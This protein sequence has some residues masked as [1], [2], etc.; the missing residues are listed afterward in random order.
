MK[1]Q[2]S[3]WQTRLNLLGALI[4]LAGL[5]SAAVIYH[6]SAQAPGYA[7]EGAIL[8]PTMS[9]N[10]KRY[11]H[12]LEVYGGRANVMLD[13]FSRWFTGLW[14]GKAL[15]KTIAFLSLVIAAGFFYAANHQVPAGE[16]A[17]PGENQRA[18][19]DL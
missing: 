15:A 5:L 19:P 11:R 8:Y 6:H 9:E 4:L 16:S 17:G 1:W 3:D 7:G 14:Q 13:D 10:T 12:E 18:G 2:F